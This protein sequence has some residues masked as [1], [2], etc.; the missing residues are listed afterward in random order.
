MHKKLTGFVFKITK[1]LAWCVAG[2]F[3]TLLGV[4]VYLM[5][6]RTDLSIWHTVNL[7][8]EFTIES[9]IE[10]FSDYLR[11]EDQ[12]FEQLDE[13]V[14]DQVPTGPSR[15]STALAGEA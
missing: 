1:I 4:F 7:D 14:F 2:G 12:V 10:N 15:L 11:I 3:L 5:E 9:E 6:N 13:L 8:T